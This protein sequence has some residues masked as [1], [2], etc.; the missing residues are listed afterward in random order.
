MA[1]QYM[2]IN[3]GELGL[4]SANFTTGTSSTSGDDIELRWNDAVSISRQDLVL[5]LDRMRERILNHTLTTE[6]KL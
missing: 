6:I 2:S 1:Q 5:A 3:R 4:A